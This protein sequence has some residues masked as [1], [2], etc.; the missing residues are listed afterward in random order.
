M[1]FWRERMNRLK[2]I[3]AAGA[4][5]VVVAGGVFLGMTVA[6]FPAAFE[7]HERSINWIRY[8]SAEGK[9]SVD[10]PSYP[11]LE[12]K[13][14]EVPSGGKTLD[15]NEYKSYQTQQVYYSVSYLNFPGKWRLVG[16]KTLL[17]KA[18]DLILDAD[19]GT[20]LIDKQFVDHQD[21]SA[22]QFHYKRGEEE[23]HGRLILVGTTLFKVTAVSPF[24][25][26][27]QFPPHSFLDSFSLIL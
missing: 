6:D 7:Q 24:S 22:L 10:F 23:I 14:L 2:K 26:A 8:T 25:I 5:L 16:S 4:M 17:K 3:A 12:F 11:E 18:L 15:Y 9:F 27:Q 13:H 19:R 1:H 20:Q 21:L